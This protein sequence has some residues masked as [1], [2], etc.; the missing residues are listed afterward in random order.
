MLFNEK[1]LKVADDLAWKVL[2]LL[3]P[4]ETKFNHKK[5]L[6]RINGKAVRLVG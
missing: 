6:N 4:G 2:D 1:E 5:K 3:Y